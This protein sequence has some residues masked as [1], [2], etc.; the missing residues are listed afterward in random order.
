MTDHDDFEDVLCRFRPVGP[1]ASMQTPAALGNQ[2][3]KAA[4]GGLKRLVV[5]SGALAAVA[6]IGLF[7]WSSRSS[8]H[9]AMSVERDVA[10]APQSLDTLPTEGQEQLRVAL[11]LSSGDAHVLLVEFVD[12]L[13]PAGACSMPPGREVADRYAT[14][15][16]GAVRYLVSDF[17]INADCNPSVRATIPGHE[18]SCVAAAAVRLARVLGRERAMIGWLS[19]HRSRLASLEGPAAIAAIKAEAARLLDGSPSDD[20]YAVTIDAVRREAAMGGA[21]GVSAVPRLYINGIPAGDAGGGPW[22]RDR[23][24]LAVQAELARASAVGSVSQG[25]DAPVRVGGD[26]GPVRRTRMVAPFYPRDPD[27]GI[28]AIL[29]LTVQPGG[30]VDAVK[31]LRAPQADGITTAA[32]EAAMQWEYEPL[33]LGGEPVWFI[34]TVVIYGSNANSR[35]PE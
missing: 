24:E 31:V 4:S 28:V 30:G 32:V 11:G 2:R 9:P 1:P 19:Q 16:P 17:P 35:G 13:C 12:W 7:A 33:E 6:V 25:F 34:Q 29:E 22:S 23:I 15:M 10:M 18:G 14:L 5:G 27:Q 20:D 8:V 3:T 21:V 26:I